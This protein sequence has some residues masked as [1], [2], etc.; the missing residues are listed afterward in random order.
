[1]DVPENQNFLDDGHGYRGLLVMNEQA[2]Y[3]QHS[4]IIARKLKTVNNGLE[5]HFYVWNDEPFQI[6][7]SWCCVHLGKCFK[8]SD[9]YTLR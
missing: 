6:T 9:I 1:M 4:H 2:E 5:R 8:M 7:G 3:P